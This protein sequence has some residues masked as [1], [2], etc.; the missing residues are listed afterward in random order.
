MSERGRYT[1]PD[2]AE[3]EGE[4]IGTIP[5]VL[6][7]VRTGQRYTDAVRLQIRDDHGVVHETVA[8]RPVSDA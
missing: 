5:A 1:A 3:I 8:M 2:G 7:N 4:I 6:M